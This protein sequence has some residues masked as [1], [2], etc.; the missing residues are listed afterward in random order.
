[1]Y[2]CVL[3]TC[4]CAVYYDRVLCTMYNIMYSVLC[5]F[6]YVF[7]VHVYVQSTMTVYYVHCIMYDN[8]ATPFTWM[9]VMYHVCC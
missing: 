7:Y 2:I 4:I 8:I 9:S 5:T 6:I 1:M 3:C